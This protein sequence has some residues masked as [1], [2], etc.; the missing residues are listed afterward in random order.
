MQSG[1]QS[2]LTTTARSSRY[3]SV[4]VPRLSGMIVCIAF[5][6]TP[7]EPS[8][9][10]FSICHTYAQTIVMDSC[11]RFSQP[12]TKQAQLHSAGEGIA[13]LT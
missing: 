10:I 2:L 12:V 6:I 4:H 11:F 1:T 13:Y 5:Q 7:K 3:P 9:V 8:P